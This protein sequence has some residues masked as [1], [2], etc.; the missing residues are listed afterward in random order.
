MNKDKLFEILLEDKPSD[1]L[2]ENEKD[3]F[4]FIPEMK[5]CK[6]FDHHNEWHIYDVYEHILHVVDNTPKN[7]ILRIAALFHDIGKPEVFVLDEEGIGHFHGHWVTSMRVFETFAE[8]NDIK[9]E[10]KILISNLIYYHDRRVVNMSEDIIKRFLEVFNKD[11]IGL[12]FELKK[13]D[14]KAQNSKFHYLLDEYDKSLEY[15]LSL[16]N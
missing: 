16:Y 10:D 3:L 1:L 12:L 2:K 9:I 13:A 5:E 7:L 6:G 14:L 8:Q 4:E 15:L 11:E